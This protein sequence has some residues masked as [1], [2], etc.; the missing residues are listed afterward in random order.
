MKTTALAFFLI[1]C[2]SFFNKEGDI[3]VLLNRNLPPNTK[4]GNL[5]NLD[6]LQNN[7]EDKIKEH[8]SPYIINRD[9]DGYILIQN[10]DKI[11]ISESFSSEETKFTQGTPFMIGSVT[12]TFTAEI[13]KT[14]IEKDLLTEKTKLID[15]IPGLDSYKNVTIYN[16]LTHSSG[17]PDYY[18][19]DEFKEIKNNKMPLN[20]FYNW[21]FMFPPDF[22]PGEGNSYSN[23]GYNIL[24]YVVELLTRTSF[25]EYLKN[26]VLNPLGMST[27]GSIESGRPENL[28]LGFEP[29]NLP[30]LLRAPQN[31]D[32][33]WLTGSGSIYSTPDDLL[34]WCVK[35]K[36]RLQLD[37][38]WKPFG[39][40][41]RKRG[42]ELYLE[43]NGRIPGFA[44]NI[45]IYPETDDIIIVLSRIESDAVN[46]IASNISDILAGAETN[47]PI[48]RK[49][50]QIHSD[51][52]LKYEGIYQIA[53]SF[54]VTVSKTKE[55]LGIATGRGPNL[56]YAVLDPIKRDE[57]FFRI[58][59]SE[60]KFVL[61][62][63]GL[64]N[65]LLWGNSG[66]YPKVY[67]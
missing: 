53:P 1:T 6:T 20:D 59:Y 29:G 33:S 48:V 39:W 56:N 57:F 25:S 31:I 3:K 18:N 7:L 19:I 50:Q 52:L 14:L 60:V 41:I 43:Q 46:H 32:V 38:N 55:G 64:V 11:V 10:R 47:I 63:K 40:G 30:E 45:R 2:I 17:I 5:T 16:L 28:P 9:F 4:I 27:T 21:I 34:K 58:G 62:K 24:A 26:E 23:S 22:E 44:S 54:F 35:I 37:K 49:I 42:T 66:P 13:I 65:A 12:K 67:K 15:L 36:Q 8:I 61:D 51:E